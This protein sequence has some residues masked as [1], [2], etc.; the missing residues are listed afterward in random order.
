MVGI[1]L[2]FIVGILKIDDRVCSRR[3]VGRKS[4][5]WNEYGKKF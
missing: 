4:G 2:T 3:H 5:E 1:L